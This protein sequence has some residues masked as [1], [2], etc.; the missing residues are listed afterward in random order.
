MYL[1]K[2][3][4]AYE[5][6]ISDWSSDVCS[7]DL[8]GRADAG[9][10]AAAV[11]ADR[12]VRAAMAEA[13]RARSLA[14][15][16]AGTRSLCVAGPASGIVLLHAAVLSRDHDLGQRATGVPRRAG[17]LRVGVDDRSAVFRSR[18]HSPRSAEIGRAHV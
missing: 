14:A 13:R 16:F 8:K 1:F 18:R 10:P 9:D 11:V 15:S 12:D 4:T 6:R 3:K 7:S 5:I 2:E 17:R